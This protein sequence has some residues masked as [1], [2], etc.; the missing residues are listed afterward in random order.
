MSFPVLGLASAEHVRVG[1]PMNEVRGSLHFLTS[2]VPVSTML[3]AR[4]RSPTFPPRSSSQLRVASRAL[5]YCSG[6]R[7]RS[8]GRP[9]KEAEAS[10]SVEHKD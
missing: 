1:G 7:A 10:N 3:G 2:S 4:L 5:L 8:A 9:A 6:L